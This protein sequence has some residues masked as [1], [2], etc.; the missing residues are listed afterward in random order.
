MQCFQSL[1]CEVVSFFNDCGVVKVNYM[2]KSPC[3]FSNIGV[4]NTLFVFL[5]FFL[6]VLNDLSVSPLQLH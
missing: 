2:V 3:M 6:L 5:I 4:F 1:S